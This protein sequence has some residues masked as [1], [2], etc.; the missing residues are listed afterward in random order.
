MRLQAALA[1]LAALVSLAAADRLRVDIE[2]DLNGNFNYFNGRWDSGYGTYPVDPRDGCQD[3]PDVPGLNNLCLDWNAQH[4]RGH[5]YFDNQ[6]KRCIKFTGV[7]WRD[8]CPAQ[9]VCN[10]WYLEEV[11]CTW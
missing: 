5:F 11:Q 10:T 1:T 9:K 7:S 3:P 6:G 4:R 8:P 2:E